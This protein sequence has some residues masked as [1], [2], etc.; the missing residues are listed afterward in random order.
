[1]EKEAILETTAAEEPQQ[2]SR[3]PLSRL[4][5]SSLP[6]QQLPQLHYCQL[7]LALLSGRHLLRLPMAVGPTRHMPRFCKV[8]LKHMEN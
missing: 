6:S 1:M 8:T 7:L 2:I 3:Y 4:C 5:H